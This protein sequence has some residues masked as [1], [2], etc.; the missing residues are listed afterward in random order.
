MTHQPY[1][2]LARSKQWGARGLYEMVAQNIG[3]LDGDEAFLVMRILDHIHVVDRIFQHHLEGRP[4]GFK[5][6]RSAVMPE[7]AHLAEDARGAT[8]GT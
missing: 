8:I 4:H 1:S 3:Q 5:A 7:L 2:L 6:A